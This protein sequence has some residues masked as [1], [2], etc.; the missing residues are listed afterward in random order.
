MKQLLNRLSNQQ[1]VHL[2]LD[3]DGTLIPIRKD[4]TELGFPPLTKK[5]LMAIQ[6][7]P[8]TILSGRKEE[9]LQAAFRGLSFNL[10]ARNGFQET[11][12]LSAQGALI[13]ERISRRLS[14]PEALG[15][16]IE[17]KGALTSLHF[18]HLG[19]PGLGPSIMN[20]VNQIIG[21]LNCGDSWHAYLGKMVVNV[22]PRVASKA[23]FVANYVASLPGASVL[24]AGDDRNDYPV[25]ELDHPRL[26]K[27]FIKSSDIPYPSSCPAFTALS[28]RVFLRLLTNLERSG[29]GE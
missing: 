7:H 12:E 28:R 24:F 15:V 22:E 6:H 2:V 1:E 18:R 10:V 16:A 13:R 5:A 19:A 26:F 14:L 27:V 23:T 3:F 20:W 21:E 11:P 29:Q 9:E 17:E 25:F 8:V 4:R